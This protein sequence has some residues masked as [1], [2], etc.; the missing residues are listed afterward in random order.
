MNNNVKLLLTSLLIA[1]SN[2]GV[3]LAEKE[4]EHE[5]PTVIP[6]PKVSLNIS[7][8]TNHKF[9]LLRQQPDGSFKRIEIMPNKE[10]K[11]FPITMLRM[12]EEEPQPIKTVK[13]D[14]LGVI[15]EI[16]IQSA[17]F[18]PYPLFLIDRSTKKQYKFDLMIKKEYGEINLEISLSGD[19]SIKDEV[20]KTIHEGI[21]TEVQDNY[22]IDLILKGDDLNDSEIDFSGSVYRL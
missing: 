4:I 13:V 3:S 9:L 19:G 5:I 22:I 11:K 15:K 8:E 2:M 20:K 21:I 12:Q 16:P 6:A 7:N 17:E 10:I 1:S 18:A 14:P